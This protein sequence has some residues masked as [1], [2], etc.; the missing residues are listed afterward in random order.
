[1][2]HRL[3]PLILILCNSD[4]VEHG[5]WVANEKMVYP[6]LRELR[7]MGGPERISF[8][9]FEHLYL[10]SAPWTDAHLLHVLHVVRIDSIGER[11]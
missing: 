10:G 11:V 9:D 1:M 5:R 8:G 2:P 4:F 3:R 6:L 7:H